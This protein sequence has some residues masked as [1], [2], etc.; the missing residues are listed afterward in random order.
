[1]VT[2][3]MP[4]LTLSYVSQQHILD[5]E[6]YHY[7]GVVILDGPAYS[8]AVIDKATFT[9]QTLAGNP[10]MSMFEPCQLTS[11]GPGFNGF[12]AH[13]GNAIS[14]GGL[15]FQLY[16][17]EFDMCTTRDGL[18]V[19]QSCSAGYQLNLT[20]PA[21]NCV[22]TM[23]S[24]PLGCS[25]PNCLTCSVPSTCTACVAGF[26]V[27]A[28][29]TCDPASTP[30]GSTNSTIS[31]HPAG[32]SL[33]T[34]TSSGNSSS[35]ISLYLS[36]ESRVADID[37]AVTITAP[38]L[39]DPAGFLRHAALR[40][41]TS[42]R[43]QD[44][45]GTRVD[46]PFATRTT[47]SDTHIRVA[48]TFDAQPEV[49]Q[50]TVFCQV[51]GFQ[52]ADYPDL[53]AVTLVRGA[54][55]QFTVDIE[56]TASQL[57]LAKLK[58]DLA[59]SLIGGPVHGN[60][61][62]TMSAYAAMFVDPFN[63]FFVLMQLLKIYNKLYFINVNFGKKLAAF[64]QRLV[65]GMR[66]F[67][68][69]DSYQ[70]FLHSRATRGKLTS[71]GVTLDGLSQ[72]LPEQFVYLG[73][74]TVC[75][76]TRLAFFIHLSLP[77]KALW[78]IHWHQKLH[79]L[80]FSLVFVDSIWLASRTLLHSRRL[81]A[82]SLF[83][84]AFYLFLISL[85][86]LY[87]MRLV[88]E[89]KYWMQ[90]LAINDATEARA[91]APPKT[92]PQQATPKPAAKINYRKTYAVLG[93]NAQTVNMMAAQL[94]NNSRVFNALACRNDYLLKLGRCAAYHAL[95]VGCQQETLLL[96]CALF[97]LEMVKVA[98]SVYCYVKYKYLKN[99]ISLLME[100]SQSTFMMAFLVVV[101][102]CW[103]TPEGSRPSDLVQDVGIWIALVCDDEGEEEGD[104]GSRRGGGRLH[105]HGE[106]GI[107][108]QS[109]AAQQR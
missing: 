16:S 75:A 67:K 93:V 102:I 73:S 46:L 66:S 76:L 25:D 82:L 36:Q 22:P 38:A 14:A 85:D 24:V 2:E 11:V 4:P 9:L 71:Y 101:G 79:V 103:Q 53:N 105:P 48:L 31:T 5:F 52:L 27:S 95:I 59:A 96:L 57:A 97:G 89:K 69:E 18:S 32:S 70:L 37:I 78:L 55:L 8:I 94:E 13:V 74:W 29:S 12:R 63:V 41:T 51:D 65:E 60:R 86:L 34:S 42:F 64:L 88:F 77:K 100:V 19:C 72:I 99:I 56:A 87:L 54:D 58:G 91:L 50:L 68:E 6:P 39:D 44:S 45:N 35:E 40:T 28:S 1:M 108:E 62:A 107:D 43:F 3:N 92:G 23:A 106:T 84:A 30:S 15:N 10:L 98:V 21:Q 7:I 83:R 17:L 81:P 20:D 61:L 33:P 47:V 109:P 90:T 26:Q 80:V 49:A 104:S